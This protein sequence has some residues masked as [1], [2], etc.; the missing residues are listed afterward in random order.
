MRE[1]LLT[2]GQSGWSDTA[3]FRHLP[4]RPGTYNPAPQ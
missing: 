3:V 4:P 1:F 2:V